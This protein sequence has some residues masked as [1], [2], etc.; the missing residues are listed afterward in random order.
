MQDT[1][2]FVLQERVSFYAF[3]YVN[4]FFKLHVNIDIHHYKY[5]LNLI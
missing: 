1:G 5:M 3:K 2:I 4:K